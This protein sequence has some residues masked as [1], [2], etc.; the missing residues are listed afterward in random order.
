MF[1]YLIIGLF[2]QIFIV[3]ERTIRLPEIWKGWTHFWF[4]IGFVGAAM[5]NIAIW[6]ITIVAEACDIYNNQ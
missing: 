3:I 1:T 5:I 4:W 2:I 6:P